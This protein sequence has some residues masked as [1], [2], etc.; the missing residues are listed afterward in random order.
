MQPANAITCPAEPDVLFP[1]SAEFGLGAAFGHVD[2]ESSP[3]SMVRPFGLRHVIEPTPVEADLS[4]VRY[5][6]ESQTAVAQTGVGW[7]SLAKHSTGQT[8]TKTSD[9]K[10]SMDSDTD[11]TED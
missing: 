11:Q 6:S 9:G 1:A 2:A 4:A 8:S 3:P 7:V 10:G 5:D